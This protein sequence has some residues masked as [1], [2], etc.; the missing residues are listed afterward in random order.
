MWNP[1][2]W[3][4]ESAVQLKESGILL[5]IGVRNPS[6]IDNESGIHG[7]WNPDS[8]QSKF[9]LDFLTRGDREDGGDKLVLVSGGTKGSGP[10]STREHPPSLLLDQTKNIF[11]DRAHRPPYL[12]VWM[13]GPPLISRSGSGT[14]ISLVL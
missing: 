7:V 2:S 14:A 12:R 4:L 3:A 5:T 8:S 9:V 1:K 11:G 10:G 6:S 13:T